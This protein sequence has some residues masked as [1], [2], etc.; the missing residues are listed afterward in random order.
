MVINLRTYYNL[1]YIYLYEMYR[2]HD[3]IYVS[4]CILLDSYSMLPYCLIVCAYMLWI[5]YKFIQIFL[6]HRCMLYYTECLCNYIS[7]LVIFKITLL[8]EF[9]LIWCSY[10]YNLFL[11][12]AVVCCVT[13][14]TDLCSLS[15]LHVG[16]QTWC[17]YWCS[18]NVASCSLACL[19][20]LPIFW[21]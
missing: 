18:A 4:L 17:H 20:M 11:G 12:V 15:V 1:D 16:H 5:S 14:V 3:D 8:F 6:V 2:W 21:H 9:F 13:M 10:H 19:T 7:F